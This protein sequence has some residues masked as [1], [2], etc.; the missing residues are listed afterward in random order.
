MLNFFCF[1]ACALFFVCFG[2]FV[3]CVVFFVVYCFCFFVFCIVLLCLLLVVFCV[4][5]F[6]L[7]LFVSVLFWLVFV[8][9][10]FCVFLCFC[11]QWSS[12]VYFDTLQCLQ[13]LV[14]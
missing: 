11:Q 12:S 14:K 8:C 7:F 4:L 9:L 1:F 3:D 6:C 10:L 2:L 13:P 5:C